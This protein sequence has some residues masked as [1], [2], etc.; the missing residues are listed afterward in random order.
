MSNCKSCR[1][2][3]SRK[4]A[5]FCSLNCKAEWQRKAKPVTKEWLVEKYL[6]ER[7]GC[8]EISKLVNRHPKNVY[9]WLIDFGIETRDRQT[10]VIEFNK[11][12]STRKKRSISR[13]GQKHN[14]KTRKIISEKH[15]GKKGLAGKDNPM[16]KGGI[17]SERADFTNSSVWKQ[18]RKEIWN[19][20]KSTCQRCK[21]LFNYEEDRP[22]HVHHIVSFQIENLRTEKSNLALLCELCHNWVHS[23][24]NQHQ[25]FLK[26]SAVDVANQ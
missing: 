14:D 13:K 11:R 19:R 7:L 4:N 21:K 1:K 10:S 16:W 8:Y 24:K 9:R 26:E 12:E 23:K 18:T 6:V 17:S 15:L 5:I 25:K 22:F 2:E 3:I 20:D